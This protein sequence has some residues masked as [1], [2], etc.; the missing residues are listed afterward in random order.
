MLGVHNAEKKQAN[1]YLHE[2]ERNEC[3]DPVGPADHME[4]SSLRGIQVVLMSS[5]SV[6]NF[7]SN[8][9]RAD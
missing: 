4:Q 5:Q 1:G 3:L 8:Q 7:R 6:D 9:S 2:C